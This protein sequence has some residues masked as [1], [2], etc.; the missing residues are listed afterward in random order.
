[1]LSQDEMFDRYMRTNDFFTP[2]ERKSKGIETVDLGVRPWPVINVGCWFFLV[3]GYILKSMIS[4]IVA[5]SFLMPSL[6]CAVVLG[7]K[8]STRLI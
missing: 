1:M 3:H 7:G 2:E 6:F 8:L 4:N 5:G